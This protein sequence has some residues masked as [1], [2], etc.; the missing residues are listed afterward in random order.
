MSNPGEPNY[1][2]MNKRLSSAILFIGN[3]VLIPV[4]FFVCTVTN[5]LN[6]YIF[7]R[8]KMNRH[9]VF[10]IGLAIADIYH[11]FYPMLFQFLSFGLCYYTHCQFYISLMTTLSFGCRLTVFFRHSCVLLNY[12]MILVCSMD[13]VVAIFL[14]IA[15]RKLKAKFAWISIITVYIL[16]FASI[17]PTISFTDRVYFPR[18]N[19]TLCNFLPPYY[20]F[21]TA[22]A[23]IYTKTCLLQTAIIFLVNILLIFKILRIRKK[24]L[25]LRGTVTND[26]ANKRLLRNTIV[27]VYIS[28]VFL[29]SVLPQACLLIARTVFIQTNSKAFINVSIWLEI[30]IFPI[31]I[32]SGFNWIIYLWRKPSYLAEVCKLLSR[33]NC[34]LRYRFRRSGT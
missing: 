34:A 1:D 25:S 28:N 12:N 26:I 27:N 11:L 17:S 2:N 13:R 22:S 18:Q 7:T 20:E 5:V 16:T 14:P 8:C 19:I 23:L 10:L 31:Y 29:I 32:Q 33:V 24:H 9:V 3:A 21:F 30:L 6:I 4:I 15:S